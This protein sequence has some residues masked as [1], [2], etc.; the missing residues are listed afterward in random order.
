MQTLVK[1]AD[2]HEG[3]NFDAIRLAMALL[4]VWSHSFAL[5]L[6]SEKAEWISVILNGAYGYGAGSL[7]VMA[8]FVISGFLIAQSWERS[9]SGRSYFEKRIRRIYPGFMVATSLCAFIIAPMFGG[10]FMNPALVVAGN[11]ALRGYMP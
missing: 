11:L 1:R 5:H 2:A 7:G 4:V 9:S 6:G 8:F 10:A 3:N